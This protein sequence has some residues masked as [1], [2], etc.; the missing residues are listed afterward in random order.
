MAWIEA[1]QKLKDHPKVLDLMN[2][3]Q[4]DVDQTIGKL[5][6]FWW[7][8]VDYAEDGDLGKHNDARIAASVGLNG[9]YGKEFVEAMVQSGWIDRDPYFR[10][11]DWWDCIGKYLQIKYKQHPEKWRKVQELYLNGSNN[12]I[13]TDRQTKQT[14]IK[15]QPEK[16]AD[17][18]KMFIDKAD[19]AKKLGF[20]IY[21]LTGRFYKESKL[22]EKL[23]EPVLSA[24][25]DEYL[26]RHSTVKE[27]WPYFIT[28]LKTK[29][30]GYFSQRNQSEGEALKREPIAIKDIFKTLGQLNET[31]EIIHN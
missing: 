13:Q 8:C 9:V 28:V 10:V 20:N 15:I 26:L 29:S 14:D 12:R 19:R 30:Q 16:A 31:N 25:L 22:S 6:R 2:T 17:F 5:F 3:M 1:H 4:W 18:S 23:P 7:W 24:V 11:H 21:Q 27:S